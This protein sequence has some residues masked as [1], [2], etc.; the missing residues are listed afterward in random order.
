MP[1]R[2]PT[3]DRRPRGPRARPRLGRRAA[4][5]TQPPRTPTRPRRQAQTATHGPHSAATRGGA[6]L[7]GVVPPV[8]PQGRHSAVREAWGAHGLYE[9]APTPTLPYGHTAPSHGR[10]SA[11]ERGCPAHS[12][13]FQETHTPHPAREGGLSPIHNY[14]CETQ[15]Q[16]PHIHTPSYPPGEA[17]YCGNF[18]KCRVRQVYIPPSLRGGYTPLSGVP[19]P[20]DG[21]NPGARGR[22][23]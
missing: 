14:I 17:C 10:V 4:S 13:A 16:T 8:S 15:S 12:R 1:D 9:P 22:L 2:R 19:H 5:P 7:R 11:R 20:W 6:G 21:F 23:P 18:A 3:A